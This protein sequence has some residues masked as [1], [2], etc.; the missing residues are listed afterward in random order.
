LRRRN[1]EGGGG[2]REKNCRK[3]KKEK[4]E[5]IQKKEK[6]TIE[7]KKGIKM[8]ELAPNLKKGEAIFLNESHQHYRLS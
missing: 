2:K 1:K 4:D 5:S 6:I 8:T 7:N 3:D